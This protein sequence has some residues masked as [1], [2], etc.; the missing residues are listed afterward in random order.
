MCY[1]LF[2]S[3]EHEVLEDSEAE[4]LID[5]HIA[6]STWSHEKRSVSLH[7]LSPGSKAGPRDPDRKL[8]LL[9]RR[10]SAA[11][12]TARMALEHRPWPWYLG[13]TILSTLLNDKDA[14]MCKHMQ[15]SVIK[16]M[17]KCGWFAYLWRRRCNCIS[18]NTDWKNLKDIERYWISRWV[19][20][21][22][23]P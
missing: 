14:S 13:L 17:L 6:I 9:T 10:A 2:L 21:P 1:V 15:A 16:G 7:C 11:R 5:L 18:L 23:G 20:K 19:A 12:Q 8:G 4:A 22:V 3:A